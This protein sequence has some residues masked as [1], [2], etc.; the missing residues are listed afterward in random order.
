MYYENPIGVKCDTGAVQCLKEIDILEK[1][2][3]RII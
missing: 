2:K 1:S 3:G